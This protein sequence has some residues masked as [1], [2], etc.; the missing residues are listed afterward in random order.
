M[1]F[2]TMDL[3]LF[4]FFSLRAIPSNSYWNGSLTAQ[5]QTAWADPE[6]YFLVSRAH[7]VEQTH[8]RMERRIRGAQ[9][10]EVLAQQELT[11]HDGGRPRGRK[12]KADCAAATWQKDKQQT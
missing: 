8:V 1:L 10:F 5:T 12:R 4:F 3:F 2:R 9:E 7:R 6:N 11:H